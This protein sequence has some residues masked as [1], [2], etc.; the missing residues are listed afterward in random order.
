LPIP[1]ALPARFSTPFRLSRAIPRR[2]AEAARFSARQRE[3]FATSIRRT[4]TRSAFTAF[5]IIGVFGS[6][7][8]GLY[9]GVQAVLAGEMSAG[10]LSQT[11]L[12]VMLVAGSVAVLAEVWGELLRASGATERLM[13]LLS[14]RSPIAEPAL[15]D[16]L[17]AAAGGL[18]RHFRAA[19]LSPIPSRPAQPVLQG[20]D[21]TI[22]A[23]QTV[24]LVGPSGAGKTTIFQL[25]QRF[26]DV[27]EGVIRIDGI[28]LRCRAWPNC[29][30]ASRWCRRRR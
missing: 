17:P 27:S 9:G 24:A 18:Q 1:A 8:Y 15:A 29:A 22:A 2:S 5:V 10:Q 12:Y 26:Y 20:L 28:D 25:L 7:L 13:E 14:L 4:G 6:L 19:A 23:G 16:R 3:A 30:G 11:A 21:L